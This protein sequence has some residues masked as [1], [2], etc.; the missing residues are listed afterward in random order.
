MCTHSWKVAHDHFAV[1]HVTAHAVLLTGVLAGRQLVLLDRLVARCDRVMLHVLVLLVRVLAR[2]SLVVARAQRRLV[3]VLVV[4]RVDDATATRLAVLTR[5]VFLIVVV[6]GLGTMMMTGY[7]RR[8][9]L[10]CE[11]VVH[12][13]RRRRLGRTLHSVA[14]FQANSVHFDNENDQK[15]YAKNDAK[16]RNFFLIRKT[17]K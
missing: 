8:C 6:V 1:G 16:T 15:N 3:V 5:I 7:G 4:S 17:L 13:E 12:E 11:H 14:R 9:A 2:R 10:V